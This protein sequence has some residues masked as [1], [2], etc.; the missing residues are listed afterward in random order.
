MIALPLLAC[1]AIETRVDIQILFPEDKTPLEAADNVSVR[2]WPSGFTETFSTEGTDFELEVELDPDDVERQLAIYF[3]RGERLLGYGQTLP[4][5]WN[6]AKS[7]ETR[8]FIGYPGTLATFPLAFSLPDADTVGATIE[9]LGMLAMA[10][11]GTTVFLDG[12]TLELVAA[13]PWP[14]AIEIPPAHEGAFISDHRLG[15]CR[16]TWTTRLHGQCFDVLT[17]AWSALPLAEGEPLA[18]VPR[19]DAAWVP[20]PDAPASLWIVGGGEQRDILRLDVDVESGTALTRVSDWTLETPRPG[21]HAIALVRPDDVLEPLV[22]GSPT[23]GTPLPCI[24][25]PARGTRL[26][27]T[28]DWQGLRCVQLEKGASAEDTRVLC[29]GGTRVGQPTADAMLVTVPARGEPSVTLQP[30]LLTTPMSDVAWFRDPVAVYAQG[31]TAWLMLDPASLRSDRPAAAPL[32][33]DGGMSVGFPTG[34]TLLVG[35]ADERGS[36]VDRWQVFTPAIE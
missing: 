6:G 27:P 21:A 18:G 3:A 32:R 4:F 25:L 1:E 5:T 20:L 33:A 29:G 19:P 36:P 28:E 14:D 31:S 34:T 9:G 15:A 23:D 10:S 12:R 24:E 26:G 22:A 17:D 30:D 11:D 13:S 16:V 2:L 35:G 8:V 7:I